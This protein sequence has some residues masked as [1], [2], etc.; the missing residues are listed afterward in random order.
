MDHKILRR[1]KSV[2]SFE[3]FKHPLQVEGQSS[4]EYNLMTTSISIIKNRHVDRF[5]DT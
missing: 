5:I 2:T 4:H 1:F 3:R